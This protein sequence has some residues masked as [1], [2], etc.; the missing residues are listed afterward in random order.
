MLLLLTWVGR[1]AWLHGQSPLVYLVRCETLFHSELSWPSPCFSFRVHIRCTVTCGLAHAWQTDAS[2]PKAF[3]WDV[4]GPKYI[5][6]L[7][8]KSVCGETYARRCLEALS[9]AIVRYSLNFMKNVLW[10]STRRAEDPIITVST[11]RWH[12]RN[13]RFNYFWKH[14]HN[15]IS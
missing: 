3:A 14:M 5:C 9:E 11:R 8:S 13:A 6:Y 2:V 4:E 1:H 15:E 10:E 12:R 7:F